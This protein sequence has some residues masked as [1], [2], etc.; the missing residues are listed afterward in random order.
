MWDG[1]LAYIEVPSGTPR[2]PSPPCGMVTNPDL[3]GRERSWGSEPTVWDGYLLPFSTSQ[4]LPPVPSPPCGMV[5][6]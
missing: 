1:D 5:T 6:V 2:V 3:L 4:S